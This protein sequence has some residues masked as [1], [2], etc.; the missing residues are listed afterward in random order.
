M[1]PPGLDNLPVELVHHIVSLLPTLPSVTALRST[2]RDICAKV[3]S[4]E[5]FQAAFITRTAD[6]SEASLTTLASVAAHPS[7]GRL[8][9]TVVL[10]TCLFDPWIFKSQ[11]LA[12]GRKY[13]VT[14]PRRHWVDCTAEE[15]ATARQTVQLYQERN[16]GMWQMRKNERDAELMTAIFGGM[17]GRRRLKVVLEAAVFSSY[18]ARVP[19]WMVN[20][21]DDGSG[22][23]GEKARLWKAMA[24]DFGVVLGTMARAETRVEELHLYGGAWGGSVVAAAFGDAVDAM[25]RP[26]LEA[27]LSRVKVLRGFVSFGGLE[28]LGSHTQHRRSGCADRIGEFLA[29][30]KGLEVLDLLYYK[31]CQPE[32]DASQTMFQKMMAPI[33]GERVQSLRL[34]GFR[35]FA[36]EVLELIGKC[37]DL[38]E[39][40][41]HHFELDGGEWSDVF[42]LLREQNHKLQRLTVYRLYEGP[43]SIIITKPG[44]CELPQ[45]GEEEPSHYCVY[46]MNGEQ[47]RSG[48]E[49]RPDTTRPKGSQAAYIYRRQFQSLHLY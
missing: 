44:D 47:V 34:R 9:R 20:K 1:P 29:M 27:I 25:A 39:L 48:I 37:G 8:I 45:D 22:E 23:G 43:S 13:V 46:Q 2:C 24:H 16:E 12:H 7:L 35:A 28:N 5:P 38:Q 21:T 42:D 36:T 31:A 18:G 19:A 33:V 10:R 26:A 32:D 41:L 4:S 11:H 3:T 49:Y 14:G 40:E 30:A 6:I 17:K 15:V